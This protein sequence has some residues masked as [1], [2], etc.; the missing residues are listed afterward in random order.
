MTADNIDR[1]IAL[2]VSSV[3][4]GLRL[5]VF[6]SGEKTGCSRSRLQ[7]LIRQGYVTVDGS[8][9]RASY[10]LKGSETVL[11]FIPE[12]VES[13][14]NPEEIPLDILFEDKHL[15]VVNKPAGMIVHPACGNYSG[16]LVNALLFHCKDLSGIGGVLRPGI[17]HRL[18]K[19]TSGL[20]VVA[21]DDQTHLA[22]SQQLQKRT[23]FRFYQ[24]FV[25]GVVEESDGTIEAPV[26]R[27]PS[28]RKKMA[29]TWQRCRTAITHFTVMERFDFISQVS[30]KLETGRTHQIR[31]HLSHIGHPVL[32]DPQYGG[33]NK[34][35]KSLS[36]RF[37]PLAESILGVISGQA[38]HAA[39]LGLVHPQTGK[40]LE[41]SVEMPRD[42]QKLKEMLTTQL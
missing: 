38:L 16:T 25:W 11:V 36:P 22:L 42:M 30:L 8:P 29:V 40:Y 24:A 13:T 4:K 35:L 5:D 21:K 1:R 26:G 2:S 39:R 7:Q 31:V 14:A 10:A 41:F 23:L 33:R 9:R 3:E 19:D 18:D 12:P 27:S 32:G 15:L 20:L 6:L 34:R 17:V 28:D 37:R